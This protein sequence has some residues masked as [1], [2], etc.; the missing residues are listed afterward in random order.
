M[1]LMKSKPVEQKSPPIDLA[2]N[3][4]KAGA[5]LSQ[6]AA[7][8]ETK[9]AAIKYPLRKAAANETMSK[10]DWQDKDDRISRA[11][12]WQACMHSVGLLQLNTGNTLE[13]Y[14]K[15]VEQAADAGYAYVHR[16]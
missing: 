9:A 15:L 8:T 16:A 3:A 5:I 11:G 2:Q 10:K 7:K 12:V 1:P 6:S 13:D 4:I 14:L